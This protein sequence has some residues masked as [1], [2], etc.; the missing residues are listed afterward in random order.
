MCSSDLKMSDVSMVDEDGIAIG[1]DNGI[2]IGGQGCYLIGGKNCVQIVNDNGF[3]KV[4]LDSIQIGVSLWN[5]G[6]KVV[7]HRTIT[8]LEADCWYHFDQWGWE[9]LDED[10][11]SS[12]EHWIYI[13][14]SEP[15]SLK[16]YTKLVM[17][18]LSKKDIHLMDDYDNDLIMHGWEDEDSPVYIANHIKS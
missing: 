9:E 1:N 11:V 14:Q 17:D 5:N 10:T 18:N 7:N 13:H 8:K 2:Q 3:V 4:G 12:I 6:K 16:E 15:V